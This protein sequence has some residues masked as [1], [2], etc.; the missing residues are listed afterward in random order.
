MLRTVPFYYLRHG[1]TDWNL[2]RRAQG[3]TDVPLNP[4]GIAQAEAA[5]DRLRTKCT[6]KVICT[7]P[8]ARAYETARI[9]N[10]GLNLPLHVI[11]DLK[12]CGF[13]VREGETTHDWF[14]DWRAGGVC[15]DGAE[16]YE[17]FKARALRG[18]NAALAHPGPVLIVA[19]GGVYWAIQEY[20]RLGH[21]QRIPNGIPIRHEPP[22]PTIPGW[23]A[24]LVE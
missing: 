3:H 20:G 7:S 22:T 14:R 21:D 24:R 15:P 12:E 4:T 13:G 9:V 2:Q 10:E 5:R 18:L 6:A 17:D 1:E 8:L 16:P 11:D 19:H 23:T